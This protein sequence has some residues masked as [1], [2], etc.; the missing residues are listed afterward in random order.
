MKDLFLHQPC[1]LLI[2]NDQCLTLHFQLAVSDHHRCDSTMLTLQWRTLLLWQAGSNSLP[3][4][5]SR[6]LHLTK[7]SLALWRFILAA[8][9]LLARLRQRLWLSSILLRTALWYFEILSLGQIYYFQT[10]F[11]IAAQTLYLIAAVTLCLPS[12][13]VLHGGLTW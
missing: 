3:Y 12:S 11:L 2:S 1:S 10:P 5:R 6:A 9:R 8:P 4:A 7:A 13:V